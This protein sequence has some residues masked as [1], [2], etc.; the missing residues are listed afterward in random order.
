MV[1]PEISHIHRVKPFQTF[2]AK[3]IKKALCGSL[4]KHMHILNL[5]METHESLSNSDFVATQIHNKAQ[6]TKSHKLAFL[7]IPYTT[8]QFCHNLIRKTN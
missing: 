8:S 4:N 5:A 2:F 7:Y 1:G 6:F 3:G